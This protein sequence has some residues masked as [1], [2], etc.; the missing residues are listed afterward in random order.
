MLV[1]WVADWLAGWHA[2]C[3]ALRVQV[4]P[5]F[6]TTP[7]LPQC[8]ILDLFESPA[9]P[10]PMPQCRFGS[11]KY[12]IAN[13]DHS[14]MLGVECVDN[15]LFGTQVG[16]FSTAALSL[17]LLAQPDGGGWSAWATSC[18]APRWGQ[19]LGGGRRQW[20]LRP[21]RQW[22][23]SLCTRWGTLSS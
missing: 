2:G 18:L 7:Q 5:T 23:L 15:I 10:S 22:R 12:E 17:L 13:Q 21:W 3:L 9:P 20:R 8:L 19:L 6:P 11:Y 1:G 4:S 16:C 14:L